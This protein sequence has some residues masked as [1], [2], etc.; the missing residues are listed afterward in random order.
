[1]T[2]IKSVTGEVLYTS[3]KP[4]K[5]ALEEAVA[6]GVS[7]QHANLAHELLA[8]ANLQ[9]AKLRG[10]NLALANLNGANLSGADLH[11]ANLQYADFQGADLSLVSARQAS[12]RDARLQR[13]NLQGAD[14]IWVNMKYANLHEADLTGAVLACNDLTGVDITSA[15]LAGAI[16]Y[17]HY[18]VSAATFGP[19]GSR[20]D[21]LLALLTV[22]GLFFQAGCFLGTKEEL[23]AAVESTH[24]DSKHWRDYKLAVEFLEN[25]LKGHNEN[26]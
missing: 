19:V 14:L 26:S 9:G 1:M 3:E 23:L 18:I 20:N 17:H 25:Y 16:F 8:G 22:D 13:A 7:L 24:G 6:E 4:L 11:K 21:K 5:W 2:T 12:L 10:A 15:K